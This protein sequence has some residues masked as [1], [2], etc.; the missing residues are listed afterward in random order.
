MRA[1]ATVAAALACA[2]GISAQSSSSSL[3][4]SS[5]PSAS[6]AANST[7]TGTAAA[8][9]A[10]S[11]PA[12]SNATLLAQVPA[13]ASA[14]ELPMNST[15]QSV[16]STDRAR[17]TLTQGL[18]LLQNSTATAQGDAVYGVFVYYNETTAVRNG[19]QSSTDIPWIAF[20]SCDNAVQSVVLDRAVTNSTEGNSALSNVTTLDLGNSTVGANATAGANSTTPTTTRVTQIEPS[21]NLSTSLFEQAADQGATGIVLYSLQQQ[22]CALN[23]TAFNSTD[24][25]S[26]PIFTVPSKHVTDLINGQFAS[27]A[28]PNRYFNTTLFNNAT[29]DLAQIIADQANLNSSSNFVLSSTTNYV[30]ARIAPRYQ[31][32]DS[33]N[34]VVATI[35]RATPTSASATGSVGTP[36]NAPSNEGGNTQPD[37]AAPAA[38]ARRSP[39]SLALTGFVVGAL[40]AGLGLLV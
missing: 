31:A 27:L 9:D 35:G 8:S 23:M 13:Y 30:L 15:L 40:I 7:A 14:D 18:T 11:S 39:A 22:T 4:A 32:N 19:N 25:S 21:A 26:L 10:S 34:G 12:A 3:S 16:W 20:I 38:L 2:A 36:T 33:N 28:E 24:N 5:S 6:A 17:G 1:V 29:A 37:N